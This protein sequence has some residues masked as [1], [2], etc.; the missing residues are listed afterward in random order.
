MTPWTL[1]AM[2][3]ASRRVLALRKLPEHLFA[4]A[5]RVD[6]GGVEEV[7]AK[8]ERLAEEGPA[9]FFVE[10]PGSGCRALSSPSRA[11]AP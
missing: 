9:L 5:A 2:T 10:S 8:I 6:I 11:G 3:T 4:V 7:D 1:V